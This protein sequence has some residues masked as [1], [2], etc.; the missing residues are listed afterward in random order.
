MNL[1]YP[2]HSTAIPNLTSRTPFGS[3]EVVFARLVQQRHDVLL[4]DVDRVLAAVVLH[5]D[6]DV[7]VQQ[8]LDGFLLAPVGG[9]V[10][11]RPPV[12]VL[13]VKVPPAVQ[14]QGEHFA[15]SLGGRHV[16]GRRARLRVGLITVGAVAAE[17]PLGVVQHDLLLGLAC[18]LAV[19]ALLVDVSLDEV[20]HRVRA[21]QIQGQLAVAVDR[22]Q[23]GATLY[24][25]A[26][27]TEESRGGRGSLGLVV[28]I[29]T[30]IE[31]LTRRMMWRAGVSILRYLFC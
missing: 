3:F 2:P 6:V 27:Y 17:P 29:S 21:G 16:A 14:Q 20:L 18:V 15:V 25:V 19:D 8:H 9:R 1:K 4:G 5:V 23:V 31:D 12:H 28:H 11:W 26:G 7:R 24:Q 10:Q 30:T 13:L 22:R